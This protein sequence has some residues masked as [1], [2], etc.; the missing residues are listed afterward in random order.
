MMMAMVVVWA[1]K[2]KGVG[3]DRI[4]KMIGLDFISADDFHSFGRY[5]YQHILIKWLQNTN[6]YLKSILGIQIL[7]SMTC[8]NYPTS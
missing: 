1:P 3:E 7:F 5:K 2:K 4:Q 8:A 6:N